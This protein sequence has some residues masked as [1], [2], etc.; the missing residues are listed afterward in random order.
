MGDS[1][2]FESPDQTQPFPADALLA[3][4]AVAHDALGRAQDGDAEAVEHLLELLGPLVVP[5]AGAARPLD[6]A[7]DLLAL[8]AVLQ[9]HAQDAARVTRLGPVLE[10]GPLVLTDLVVEDEPLVL[11]D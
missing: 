8:G 7:D 1:H 2:Q 5:A 4:P 9:V 10:L 6:N 3:G 11:Q